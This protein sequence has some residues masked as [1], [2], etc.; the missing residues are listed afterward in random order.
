MKAS[1]IIAGCISCKETHL[2]KTF[3][4]QK[5]SDKRAAML[6]RK[7]KEVLHKAMYLIRLQ[8]LYQSIIKGFL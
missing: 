5:S 1:N 6:R 8:S 7:G 2:F 3:L 4:T